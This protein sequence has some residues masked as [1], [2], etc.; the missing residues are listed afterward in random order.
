MK[1]KIFVLIIMS[2]MTMSCQK[3]NFSSIDATNESQS[4]PPT[5]TPA[6]VPTPD[7]GPT[8]N[9][10][11]TPAPGPTPVIQD[12][13]V[14]GSGMADILFVVNDASSMFTTLREDI[15]IRFAHFIP[16]INH[17][18]YHIAVT[19]AQATGSRDYQSGRVTKILYQPVP[20]AGLNLVPNQYKITPDMKH[21][22]QDFLATIMRPEAICIQVAGPCPNPAHF[23]QEAIHSSILALSNPDSVAK[24]IR[25]EAPLNIVIISEDDEGVGNLTDRHGNMKSDTPAYN[26][27]QTLIDLVQTKWPGKQFRVHAVI[28][29][30]SEMF[31]NSPNQYNARAGYLYHDLA[32]KTGGVVASICDNYDSKSINK[33]ANSIV[34][35]PVSFD[36]QCSPR[37]L[38]ASYSPQPAQPTQVV[39]SGNS[40]S[41]SPAL[42]LGTGVHLEYTCQ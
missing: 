11:P 18:D 41:F 12:F 21:P 7:P 15:P 1:N 36:L 34:A 42:P 2:V 8:P 29:K 40:I 27:P 28:T 6:P 9:P 5:P 26:R 10:S 16:K 32:Q 33:I 39:I 14:N 37:N 3:K 20:F 13:T 25:P 4:N 35:A 19:S 31:C 23:Y 38:T 17:L 30:P 24:F 22:G